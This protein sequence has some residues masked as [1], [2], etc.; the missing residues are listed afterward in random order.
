MFVT[1]TAHGSVSNFLFPP[2]LRWILLHRVTAAV[3][4][5]EPETIVW[6]DRCG[7]HFNN[8]FDDEEIIKRGLYTKYIQQYFN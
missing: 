4:G 5:A 1:L 6:G 2:Q 3:Q 8:I 7:S